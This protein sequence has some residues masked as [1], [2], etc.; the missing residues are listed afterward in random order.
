MTMAD[1]IVMFVIA[2][3]M[4]IAA[5][6]PSRVLPLTVTPNEMLPVRILSVILGLGLLYTSLFVESEF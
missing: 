3:I 2:V 1:R 4:L 5:C 6:I